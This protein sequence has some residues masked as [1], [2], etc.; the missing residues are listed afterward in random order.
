[1]G[2][3]TCSSSGWAWG[4]RAQGRWS[5]VDEEEEREGRKKGE[6]DRRAS[7]PSCS[8]QL[9]GEE[10]AGQLPHSLPSSRDSTT[11]INARLNRNA[12]FPPRD[13]PP[14]Q[15]LPSRLGMALIPKLHE[16]KVLIEW[17]EGAEGSESLQ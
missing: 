2:G 11:H 15:N 8:A 3:R 7:R 10:G 1:M 5:N 13:L 4:S 12:H 14:M 16:E 9:G 17:C 6:E